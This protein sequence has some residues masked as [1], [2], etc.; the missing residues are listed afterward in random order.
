MIGSMPA[1]RALMDFHACPI[2][3]GLIPDVGGMVMMGSP[4]VL[5]NSMM[6]CRAMDM[7]VEI[8]GGPNPIVVGATNV[9]IGDSGVVAPSVSA[10]AVPD[11]VV[12][13]VPEV[14]ALAAAATA[15]TE[16]KTLDLTYT[17]PTVTPSKDKEKEKAKPVVPPKDYGVSSVKAPG[18]IAPGKEKIT[19]EY[20]VVNT[21]NT[22]ITAA[23]VEILRKKDNKILK[24]FELKTA[25]FSEGHHQFLWDG[26]VEKDKE[27]PDGFVTI[28]H[29][30]YLIRPVVAGDKGDRNAAA[31]TKVE[32]KSFKVELGK[33]DY[34]ADNDLG[35]RTEE[36]LKHI[37]KL[38]ASGLVKLK[39]KSNVF[40]K[41]D[42][43]MAD[44]TAYT[45]YEKLWSDG[46]RIPMI[47]TVTILDSKGNE[48]R[49]GKAMGR[50]R[51][52]WDYTDPPQSL[53]TYK[54]VALTAGGTS[55]SQ[56]AKPYVDQARLYKKAGTLPK[57]GDNA[58]EDFGGKRSDNPGGRI[59]HSADAGIQ[60]FSFK[61]DKGATRKWAG[62][63]PFQKDGAEE[64][65][66]GAIFH[67][68]R[69]AG[70]SYALTAYLD[71]AEKLDVAA[72]KPH[73]PDREIT[74]GRFE[75]WRQVN[76]IAHF[77]KNSTV[78]GVMPTFAEYFA[79]AYIE[80]KD[81]RGAIQDLT[82]AWFDAEMTAAIGA[83]TGYSVLKKYALR[84][85]HWDQG[86]SATGWIAAF[87]S[88]SSFRNA[89]KTDLNYSDA[90][91]AAFLTNNGIETHYKYVELTSYYGADLGAELCKKKV[92]KD[93]LTI[94]QFDCCSEQEPVTWK[95]LNGMAVSKERT[96]TG[97][98]LTN[99]AAGTE[100]T[101]AHE[102]GHCMFLPHAPRLKLNAAGSA[103]QVTS[104][105]EGITP[106][107]HDG[108]NWNC[109][110]SYNRPR[111]GFC[112][113][114]LVRLRGYKG[115]KFDKNGP[116]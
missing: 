54:A 95:I 87:K 52:V 69:M 101:P 9:M 11:I 67:P 80:V 93:G 38:P 30:A 17:A 102:I 75:V 12:P 14:P 63:A 5:I 51:V 22:S 65:K 8:P 61:C 82:K 111:P 15:A 55:N 44:Q 24:K 6:A 98:L 59:F 60:N 68:S 26:T 2:V 70:D 116:K 100:Q 113:L 48:V 1:W 50:A 57:D 23:R 64:A 25:E 13:P 92:S 86:G 28:E 71:L 35:H 34:L 37:G 115:D 79:D 39:L 40:C 89:V 99:T 81:D 27:F 7:V 3:K 114:C 16:S 73:S 46:P 103:V 49:D 108:Q 85:S 83:V 66:A 112:G 29:S 4:T 72:A 107:F 45:E 78:T 76:M 18:H 31:E 41:A 104:A 97:F 110:M 19:V 88:Y 90:D 91:L 10:P 36:I 58:H 43:E 77:R 20:D 32:L 47:A 96:K 62:L 94:L 42:S 84:G 105:A 106:S 21:S 33:K 56:G 109:L 74:I 53:T